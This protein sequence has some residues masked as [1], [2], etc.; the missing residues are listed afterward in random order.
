MYKLY[1]WP[2]YCSM[3]THIALR[4]AQLEYE[5]IIAGY[6]T[7][8]SKE[9]ITLN[10]SKTVPLLITD[11]GFVISQNMAVLGYLHDVALGHVET[12]KA[13]AVLSRWLGYLNSDVH[14]TF[15][16]LMHPERIPGNEL[17]KKDVMDIARHKLR[18]H[19]EVL[20]TQLNRSTWLVGPQTSGADAYLFVLTRWA[21]AKEVNLDGFDYVERHYL[22]MLNDPDVKEVLRLEGL[23]D[24]TDATRYDIEE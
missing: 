19:F 14:K 24:V 8:Q 4:W 23:D 12:P 6:K 20:N 21:K 13:R 18:E 10:P 7:R 17:V 2:G 5:L 9:F 22:K 15:S 1:Y 16:P 3:A 11:D